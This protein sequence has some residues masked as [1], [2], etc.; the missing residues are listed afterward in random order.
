MDLASAFEKHCDRVSLADFMVI[1]GEAVIGITAAKRPEGKAP[2]GDEFRDRFRSGR[3]TRLQCPEAAGLM[4]NPENGC[5][6]LD[7][8][9]GGHIFKY[10]P[11]RTWVG[12]AWRAKTESTWIKRRKHGDVWKLI[13]A[14]NG[15]HTLGSAKLVNSGY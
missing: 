10:D 14:I 6:G 7:K 9:F 13:A 8:I 5:P 3:E 11:R 1:A 15:A 4:P 12:K 2:L